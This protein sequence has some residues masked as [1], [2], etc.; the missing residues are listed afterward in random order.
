[1]VL[2]GKNVMIIYILSTVSCYVLLLDIGD[3]KNFSESS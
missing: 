2:E 1:M 3:M